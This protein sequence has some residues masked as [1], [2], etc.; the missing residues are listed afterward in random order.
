MTS[1]PTTG[2][3]GRRGDSFVQLEVEGLREASTAL[4]NLDKPLGRAIPK[5]L[6]EF[7]KELRTRTERKGNALGG[8]HGHAVKVGGVAHFSRSTG[9][10]IKLRASKSPAIL[11]AEY[12]SHQYAQFPAWRGNQFTDAKGSGVGYMM[13]PAM[14]EFLPEAEKRLYDALLKAINEAIEAQ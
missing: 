7:A 8:V 12:G 10:G 4:R 1:G 6:R 5:G 2:P 11:G 14:R 3:V 9:A 13:H